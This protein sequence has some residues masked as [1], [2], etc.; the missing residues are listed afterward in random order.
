[1]PEEVRVIPPLVRTLGST[2]DATDAVPN[3]HRRR[4]AV[5]P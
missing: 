1:M 3:L 4:L 5:P 2:S